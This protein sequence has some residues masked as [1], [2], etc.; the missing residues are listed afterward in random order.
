MYRQSSENIFF[1][2]S[3][4]CQAIGL[5]NLIEITLHNH[6]LILRYMAIM[7]SHLKDYREN[8]FLPR[9]DLNHGPT[10]SLCATNELR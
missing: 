5:F 8:I 7:R 6:D 1:A 2:Q 3:F 10:K 9:R 4:L